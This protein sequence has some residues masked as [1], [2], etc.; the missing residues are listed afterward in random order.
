MHDHVCILC[1]YALCGLYVSLLILMSFW[2]RM[3]RL[4]HLWWLKRRSLSQFNSQNR[5]WN[6]SQS[7]CPK[8]KM[9]FGG[10]LFCFTT[11]KYLHFVECELVF[12]SW[13]KWWFISYL[14]IRLVNL[15]K[16]FY[17]VF[18]MLDIF[19]AVLSCAHGNIRLCPRWAVPGFLWRA[20]QYQRCWCWWLWQS[21]ALQWI[22]EGHLQIP[23]A[24]WG[25]LLLLNKF[26]I[27]PL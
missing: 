24:T 19:W 27:N 9:R 12:Q 2:S 25:W 3:W 15:S 22:C 18:L 14:V 16:D 5:S 10:T 17:Y 1:G 6:R 21:H 20:S 4:H 26:F 23:P 13:S 7:S 8:W 11:S